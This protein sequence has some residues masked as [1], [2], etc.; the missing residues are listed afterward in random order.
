M[1]DRDIR[2]AFGKEWVE[3]AQAEADG[4]LLVCSPSVMEIMI[5]DVKTA[6]PDATMITIA[7]DMADFHIG[8]LPVVTNDMLIG[9]VT[10]TDVVRILGRLGE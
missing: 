10:D 5:K 4:K 7:Q 1:S 2:R 6:E 8:A 9:I 3:D